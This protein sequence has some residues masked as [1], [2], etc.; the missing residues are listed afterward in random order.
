MTTVFG[1]EF[2]GW[3]AWLP[4]FPGA[5]ESCVASRVGSTALRWS[6]G[7]VSGGQPEGGR[8]GPLQARVAHEFDGSR[9]QAVLSAAL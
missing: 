7:L 1:S 9:R 8:R 4:L 5:R 6:P 2:L 3:A